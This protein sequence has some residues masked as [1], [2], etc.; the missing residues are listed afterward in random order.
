MAQLHV[1]TPHGQNSASIKTR[2]RVIKEAQVAKKMKTSV[3]QPSGSKGPERMAK[4][5]DDNVTDIWKLLLSDDE[6]APLQENFAEPEDWKIEN[7]YISQP[8][9]SAA[10][11][12]SVVQLSVSDDEDDPLQENFAEPEDWKP[13]NP[14]ISQPSVSQP[15]ES[16]ASLR[17]VPT[18]AADAILTDMYMWYHPSWFEKEPVQETDEQERKTRAAVRARAQLRLAR[19]FERLWWSQGWLRPWE[20]DL[21]WKL[22]DGTMQKKPRS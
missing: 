15:S 5:D 4:D 22:L 14:Y 20:E 10:S 12:R 13:E 8:S 2:Q 18:S 9:G 19:K 3:F 11:L 16:S 17:P 7:P 1:R 6:D 21:V